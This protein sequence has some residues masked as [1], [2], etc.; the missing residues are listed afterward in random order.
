MPIVGGF[1]GGVLALSSN[2]FL[3]KRT[4]QLEL[5]KIAF[6]DKFAAGTEMLKTARALRKEINTEFLQADLRNEASR[7]KEIRSQIAQFEE[8][9]ATSAWLFEPLVYRS[10]F[11][12][13]EQF[14]GALYHI[15]KCNATRMSHDP[16][17]LTLK[18]VEEKH[19]FAQ[20]FES[21]AARL[22]I[23][24]SN[25]LRQEMQVQAIVKLPKPRPRDD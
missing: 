2:L 25:A 23:Q 7:H 6:A 13:N 18:A 5:H 17:F 21:A 9:V 15:S 8:L 11:D 14:Y 1:I 3:A 22:Y 16:N 4:R 12:L 10:A 20:D 19:E 24:L